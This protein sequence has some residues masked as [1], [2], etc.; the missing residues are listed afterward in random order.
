LGDALE[1]GTA[2]MTARVPEWMKL[3][4]PSG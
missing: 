3:P 2:R 1:C 4:E